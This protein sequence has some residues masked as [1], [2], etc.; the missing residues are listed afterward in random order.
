MGGDAHHRPLFATRSDAR[1]RLR[2]LTTRQAVG[3]LGLAVGWSCVSENR[4]TRDTAATD[5]AEVITDSSSDA[6]FVQPDTG[7]TRTADEPEIATDSSADAHPPDLVSPDTTEELADVGITDTRTIDVAGLD[8]VSVDVTPVDEI[9]DDGPVGVDSAQEV[10]PDVGPDSDVPSM[11]S[12]LPEATLPDAEQDTE[13]DASPVGCFAHPI[14]SG[15]GGGIVVP[16]VTEGAPAGS[17]LG[18]PWT[19]LP[20]LSLPRLDA[21]ASGTSPSIR[22]EA[23][24]SATLETG[25]MA[26]FGDTDR[27]TVRFLL[28]IDDAFS[29]G[30][31][32]ERA[33]V[34]LVGTSGT[35][36]LRLS[37]LSVHASG[38]GFQ[39]ATATEHQWVDLALYAGPTGTFACAGGAMLSAGTSIGTLTSIEISMEYIGNPSPITGAAVLVDELRVFVP[40]Q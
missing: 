40:A 18:S 17:Q 38:G 11:D 28:R 32:V 27:A 39:I 3:L 2:V 13:P 7:D 5:T 34:R 25:A 22:L 14:F 35:R 31:N 37:G 15:V 8:E 23:T 6:P 4:A 26:T 21:R 24:A 9:R 29:A 33:E 19:A 20:N 1:Y 12:S 36:G 16:D 10:G 30:G